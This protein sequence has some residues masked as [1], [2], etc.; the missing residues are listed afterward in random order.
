MINN[1]VVGFVA[2][3]AVMT[4]FP[5]IGVK[6]NKGVRTGSKSLVGAYLAWQAKRA[7]RKASK[8]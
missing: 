5:A 8:P 2:C 7:A 1:F 6:I 4:F 3:A